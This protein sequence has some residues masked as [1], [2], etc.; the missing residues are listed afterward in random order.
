[1][2]RF[3]KDAAFMVLKRVV[4][5]TLNTAFKAAVRN[6]S[7]IIDEIDKNAL[8]MEAEENIIEL[9]IQNIEREEFECISGQGDTVD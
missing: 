1:V 4:I 2:A 9:H 5:T 3:K 8:E 6:A 7:E